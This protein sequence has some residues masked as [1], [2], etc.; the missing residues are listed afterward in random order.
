MSSNNIWI[1]D[2]RNIVCLKN[3]AH[4]EAV[5]KKR[6]K[7][8]EKSLLNPRFDRDVCRFRRSAET[9]VVGSRFNEK[10]KTSVYEAYC[11][12]DVAGMASCR[13]TICLAT[14]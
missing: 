4:H 2:K 3:V 7:L 6:K 1:S 11:Q 13:F 8:N 9:L 12:C 14:A 10:V 5:A